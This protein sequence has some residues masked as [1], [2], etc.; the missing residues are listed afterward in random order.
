MRQVDDIQ[1][2]FD[3]GEKPKWYTE[4]NEP[5]PEAGR[6]KG[7]TLIF[8]GHTDKISSGTVSDNFQR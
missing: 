4:T 7:L 8:D 3:D 1:H 6:K 5:I 2:G